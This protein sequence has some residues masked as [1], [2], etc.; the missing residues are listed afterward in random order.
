MKTL[1]LVLVVSASLP[2][3]VLTKSYDAARTSET[4]SETILTV[5]KVGAGMQMQPRIPCIGDA[6][7]CEAQPL[8]D[9]GVMLLASNGNVIRGVKPEDGAG[10][11][12]TPVLCAPVRSVPQNDMW[13]VNEHFGMLS[14]G[15]ID[16]DTHKLYQV[17]TCSADGTGSHRS[18][19]QRMFVIDTRNGTVLANTVL[20]AASNGQR[21][22]DAPRKQRAALALWSRNGVKFIVIA[23]GSF[24]E[25]GENATGWILAFDTFDNQVKAAISTR[26]GIWMSG[27]GPS[28]DRNG[29]I[30]LGAGNGPFNGSTTFGEAMMQVQLTPP[31]A[32]TPAR[33]AVLHAWAPYSDSARTC[34][35]AQLTQ[36]RAMLMNKVAGDSAPSNPPP[37]ARMPMNTDCGAQW[38]DQDAHLSGTLFERF[39]LY[40]T[41]GKDGIG[42]LANTAQF[43]DTQPSDFSNAKAN[44][45][46]VKMFQLGWDLGMDSCPAKLAGLNRFPGAKTRHI[47]SPLAQHFAPDSTQFVLAFAE[48]SPLQ[49]W[50]LDANGAMTFV[51]RGNEMA[52][53]QSR[54]EHGGMPGGFCSVSSNR[55]ANAIAW[56][57]IP[58]G[59]ANRS[60][61]TGRLV[62][63]DLTGFTGGRIRTLWTSEQFVFSK[64]SQPVVSNG[65]VYLADYAGSVMVWH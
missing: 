32:T 46:K 65:R 61:T 52:S 5:A 38:G 49:A 41:A 53:A 36:P 50:R 58:D 25:T 8:I 34:A 31:T 35:N 27:G 40:L 22:S 56:C 54:A 44:C 2:A 57:A 21:Y 51:A 48:N 7:G 4:R 42:Y 16:P 9:G 28:I 45:A 59:D 29:L 18:M 12:Q 19:N 1:V 15:V 33:L 30:Y 43:P 47:H 39:N 37:G 23:A 10:I 3:Q 6:R 55:G 63:Y 26:A 13:G 17:A 64:F 24:A 60:V 20:D 11:W 14:T 62:A